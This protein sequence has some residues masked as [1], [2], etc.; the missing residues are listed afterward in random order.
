MDM[1]TPKPVEQIHSPEEL[2]RAFRPRDQ[3]HVFIPKTMQFPL[4][5][6]HYVAWTEPSGVRIFLVFKRPGWKKAVGVAFRRDQQ[7]SAMSPTGV[8][9]WCIAHGS[10]DQVGLLTATVNSKKRAGV[11]LC[12]D[13]SCIQKL[14]TAA[15]LSGQELNKLAERLYERMIRFCEEVLEIQCG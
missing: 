10:A 9:D 14:E 11:N 12:L 8:C 15:H 4:S 1:D 5:L 7:G 13:L 3:K 6:K 2:I